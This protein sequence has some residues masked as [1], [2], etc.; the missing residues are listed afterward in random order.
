MLYR[1]LQQ[2][3]QELA[4][5]QALQTSRLSVTRAA[6]KAYQVAPRPKRAAA[7]GIFLGLV[8]GIGLMFLL[9]A[10][11]TRVRSGAEIAERLDLPLLSR[12]PGRRASSR[13]MTRW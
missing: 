10:L 1:G 13:R 3:D 6:A 7:L 12:I 5:L 8:V 9:E 11:D 2:K 4:T